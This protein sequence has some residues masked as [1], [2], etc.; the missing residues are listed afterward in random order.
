MVLSSTFTISGMK[1]CRKLKFHFHVKKVPTS[2]ALVY[3]FYH[4]LGHGVSLH[5]VGQH[6]CFVSLLL[7]SSQF[8]LTTHCGTV[9]MIDSENPRQ[10]GYD[11]VS[12][13]LGS[14]SPGH[15]PRHRDTFCIGIQYALCKSKPYWGNRGCRPIPPAAW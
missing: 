1:P 13:V 10:G 6:H 15:S 8:S 3:H 12:R 5:E 7:P 9:R 4:F 14:V 2:Y 11:L